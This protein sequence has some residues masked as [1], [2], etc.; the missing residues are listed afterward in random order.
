MNILNHVIKIF[1]LCAQRLQENALNCCHCSLVVKVYREECVVPENV[2][3]H[4]MEGRWKFREGGA[5]KT[6]ILKGECEAKLDFPDT[7]VVGW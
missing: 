5:F 4:P 6:K 3:I 1:S 2:H 7:W